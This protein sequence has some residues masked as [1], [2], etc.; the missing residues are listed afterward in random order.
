LTHKSVGTHRSDNTLAQRDLGE[1]NTNVESKM[2]GFEVA[3]FG[4]KKPWNLAYTLTSV[5][6]AQEQNGIP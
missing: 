2:E 6:V 4:L 3:K 5:S 1:T